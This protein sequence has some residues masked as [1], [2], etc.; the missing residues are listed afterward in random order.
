MP[1]QLL[2]IVVV[3]RARSKWIV[4][5]LHKQTLKPR[6][7]YGTRFN[8]GGEFVRKISLLW[9]ESD[10]QATSLIWVRE[11]KIEHSIDTAGRVKAGSNEVKTFVVMTIMRLS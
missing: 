7:G 1:L 9:V 11:T 6:H 8:Q 3:V 2:Q 5:I 4:R 10:E